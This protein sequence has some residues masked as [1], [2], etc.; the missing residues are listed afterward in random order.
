MLYIIR[1]ISFEYSDH[2]KMVNF[3]YLCEYLC[4]YLCEYTYK[5]LDL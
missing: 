5:P 3:T 4:K 2:L 1:H